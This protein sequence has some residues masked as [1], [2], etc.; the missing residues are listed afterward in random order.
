MIPFSTCHALPRNEETRDAGRC[1]R[2]TAANSAITRFSLV[3]LSMLAV[4]LLSAC[5]KIE[6]TEDLLSKHEGNG[7]TILETVA[8]IREQEDLSVLLPR[9]QGDKVAFFASP[10]QRVYIA[11]KPRWENAEVWIDDR[12]NWSGGRQIDRLARL[13]SLPSDVVI[14]E[15]SQLGGNDIPETTYLYFPIQLRGP[16]TIALRLPEL[17]GAS[18]VDVSSLSEL[19]DTAREWANSGRMTVLDRVTGDIPDDRL[20]KFSTER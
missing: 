11:I 16:D 13:D 3:I 19:S 15:S 14:A 2:A 5:Y 10:D 4:G 12:K 18:S 20:S 6:A 7:V 17:G 8:S 1:C 9:D